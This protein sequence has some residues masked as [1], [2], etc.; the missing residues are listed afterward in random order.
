MKSSFKPLQAKHS[1]TF[2]IVG[3]VTSVYE[4]ERNAMY[5]IRANSSDD[6]KYYNT[7][8]VSYHK[9]NAIVGDTVITSGKIVS[10]FDKDVKRIRHRFW[11]E[12]FD[13]VDIAQTRGRVAVVKRV[14]GV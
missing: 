5:T 7:Y 2:V 1:A 12:H 13:R 14:K 3:I 10:Y 4:G 6:G 9:G 8:E 11:A